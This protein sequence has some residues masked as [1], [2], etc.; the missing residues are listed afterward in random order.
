[1]NQVDCYSLVI[2]NWRHTGEVDYFQQDFVN[3]SYITK[4]DDAN[5]PS[6]VDDDDDERRAAVCPR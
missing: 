2:L 1:M 6:D 3:G 4:N 5:L